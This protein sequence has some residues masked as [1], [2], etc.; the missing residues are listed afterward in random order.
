MQSFDVIS[1]GSVTRDVF[2]KTGD[3]KVEKNEMFRTGVAG[4]LEL[5]AKLEVPEVHFSG[6]GGGMNTAI[7]FGRQGFKTGCVCRVG[8]DDQDTEKILRD[9]G[10]EPILQI[11]KERHTAYSTILVAANGERT[12]LE[13]RGAGDFFNDKD[14]DWDNIKAKWV[15]ID[16]LAGNEILLEKILSWAEK[17]GS[18]VAYN[19]DKRI[20]KLGP[21]I[22]KYLDRVDIFSVNED[23]AA[24][25]A[26]ME[27]KEENEPQ[28][29][30]KLDEIVRGIVVM[31]KGPRGVVVS[32]GK[33]RY[34]AG[35]PDSP[36]IE[37]TGAGDAFGSGFTSGY[38]LA[39]E[40]GMSEYEK[41]EYAIQL[42]TANATS[43]VLYY[44]GQE[45]CLKK[46]DWGKYG[47]VEVVRHE[48]KK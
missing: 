15:Y 19:P 27:Y 17:N 21:A 36:V 23:E 29:F 33:T 34:S 20:I 14:T 48:L 42:G 22:K 30:E 18:R 1:I 45:G 28:I 6:G 40:A 47:K 3:F 8:F 43:V 24:F 7:T 4:C 12:I 37:R 44:G 5:G 10:V 38:I 32:N 11:D 16:S 41:I 46:G 25:V 13:Y 31:S 35:V 2:L 39:S 26:G 9:N